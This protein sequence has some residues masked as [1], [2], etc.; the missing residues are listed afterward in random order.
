MARRPTHHPLLALRL[1]LL[2]CLA[3]SAA[4]AAPVFAPVSG[5]L[6]APL[7]GCVPCSSGQ[8]VTL[9]FFYSSAEFPWCLEDRHHTPPNPQTSCMGAYTNNIDH[10]RWVYGNRHVKRM[11]FVF[12]AFDLETYWDRFYALPTSVAP[13]V[14][15]STYLTGEQ[16]PLTSYLGFPQP[17]NCQFDPTLLRFTTDASNGT[18]YGGFLIESVRVCCE[19][20]PETYAKPSQPIPYGTRISG[21][22]LGPND[23]VYLQLPPPGQFD[24]S[25]T[26][27]ALWSDQNDGTAD[28][29]LYA[30]CNVDPTPVQGGYFT[31]GYHGVQPTLV[32]GQNAE[33]VRLP[34]CASGWRL[35]V[36]SYDLS[37]RASRGTFHLMAS[38]I[39]LTQFREL[40]IG[41]NFEAT[42]GQL[43]QVVS[44]LEQAARLLYGATEG[45]EWIYMHLYNNRHSDPYGCSDCGGADCDVC[46]DNS[47]LSGTTYD[48][49]APLPLGKRRVFLHLDETGNWQGPHTIVHELAHCMF[50]LMDEYSS[51]AFIPVGGSKC[52]HSIMGGGGTARNYNI[53]GFCTALDHGKDPAPPED[54]EGGEP[55]WQTMSNNGWGSVPML[56]T[57]D[58]FDFRNHPFLMDG[59]N[60]IEVVMH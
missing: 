2:A 13:L 52:G 41:M 56:Q 57:P 30:Q 55:R 29:D 19:S 47:Y 33:F 11:Q 12:S 1:A 39:G 20:T 36:H 22:L 58:N 38:K 21:V 35:A 27:I 18:R 28:F 4:A 14:E 37:P 60:Q 8:T 25:Q 43:A 24:F 51:V 32:A 15:A 54:S 44:R 17:T 3:P 34:Y 46:F 26:Q 31:R 23:V 40:R 48:I 42:Q 50:G 5:P 6:P 9:P 16:P 7:V 45:Q 53:N 49:C 59:I 10:R